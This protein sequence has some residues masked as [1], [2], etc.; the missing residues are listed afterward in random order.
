MVKSQRVPPKG[1]VAERVEAK[2]TSTLGDHGLRVIR[3]RIGLLG[4]Y[5]FAADGYGADRN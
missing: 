1:F 2:N 3:Y 5:G 4:V